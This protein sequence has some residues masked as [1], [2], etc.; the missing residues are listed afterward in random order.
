MVK[1]LFSQRIACHLF[2]KEPI[3][4]HRGLFNVCVSLLTDRRTR[5]VFVSLFPQDAAQGALPFGTGF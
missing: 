4:R 1:V 3:P 2:V 5:L